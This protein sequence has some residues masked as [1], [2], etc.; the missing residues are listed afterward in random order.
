MKF[1]KDEV[2]RIFEK[3]LVDERANIKNVLIDFDAL[4]SEELQNVGIDK[5]L[6]KKGARI[7]MLLDLYRDLG[8]Y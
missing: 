4:P 1:N 5:F 8:L 2:R 3:R 7:E 6:A